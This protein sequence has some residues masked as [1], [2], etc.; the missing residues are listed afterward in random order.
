MHDDVEGP[1]S[2]F[3]ETREL[4]A[5]DCVGLDVERQLNWGMD[6]Q[7]AA[8]QILD[9]AD[10]YRW[11]SN[12]SN[13]DVMVDLSVALAKMSAAEG[14][15]REVAACAALHAPPDSIQ[16]KELVGLFQS[17]SEPS[18][19]SDRQIA[20]AE[21][22]VE[23]LSNIFAFH[24]DKAKD[25]LHPK[26]PKA[27]ESGFTLRAVAIGRLFDGAL[28]EKSEN[29]IDSFASIAECSAVDSPERLAAV[30]GLLRYPQYAGYK[31]SQRAEIHLMRYASPGSEIRFEAEEIIRA[32]ARFPL[33]D[34]LK[35][36]VQQRAAFGGL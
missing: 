14:L 11:G 16:E 23:A 26:I 27:G 25:R 4:L 18:V 3:L 35:V 7:R 21:D 32:D 2:Y 22:C 31:D 15:A 24:N 13:V 34:L 20:I 30:M 5:Q 33:K 9:K 1:D 19:D 29:L 17:L 36:A 8:T 6:L 10:F 12:L 28:F